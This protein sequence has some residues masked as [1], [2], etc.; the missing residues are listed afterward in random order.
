MQY[1][2]L[3]DILKRRSLYWLAQREQSEAE[4][5]HKLLFFGQSRAHRA[6]LKHGNDNSVEPGINLQTEHN[7]IPMSGPPESLPELIDRVIDSLKAQG[8]LSDQR[9]IE[10]RIRVR[11]SRFGLQRIQRE[12]AEHG[13]SLQ[14]DAL[15]QLA[16]SEFERAQSVWARKFNS[17]PSD[18]ATR[19]SQ[20]R[21][22]MQRGFSGD[23]IN[24]ILRGDG[25]KENECESNQG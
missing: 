14:G 9:F 2:K 16:E 11:Q 10:S 7:Q 17:L 8:H 18:P 6:A 3:F 22:L 25:S 24:R 21:F 1:S 4:L 12:L 15:S 19:A 13:L 20:A 5:R 23:V